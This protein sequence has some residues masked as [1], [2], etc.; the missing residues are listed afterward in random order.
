M[1]FDLGV[2]VPDPNTQAAIADPEI[3]DLPSGE[4]LT[5]ILRGTSGAYFSGVQKLIQMVVIELWSDPK[6]D[7]SGA[8]LMQVFTGEARNVDRA[9]TRSAIA[10]RVTKAR[11]N[12]IAYQSDDGPTLSPSE[13]LT[14]LLI[15]SID[16][17]ADTVTINLSLITSAGEN[18]EFRQALRIL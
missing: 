4:L 8:G 2:F 6:P 17:V 12:I 15:R 3:I 1:S 11:N 7:G 9:S 5:Q 14:D 18:V 10:Q 16:F 13:T